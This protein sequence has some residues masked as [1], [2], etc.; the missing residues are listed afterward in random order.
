MDTSLFH[1]C[2]IDSYLKV[3]VKIKTLPLMIFSQLHS[4]NCLFLNWSYTNKID[5]LREIKYDTQE[6]DRAGGNVYIIHHRHS[7]CG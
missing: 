7:I 6:I 5:V 2:A 1:L 3:I 4:C